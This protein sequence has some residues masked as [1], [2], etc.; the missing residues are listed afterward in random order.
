[1]LWLYH[2]SALLHVPCSMSSAFS[3][4]VKQ[5]ENKVKAPPLHIRFKLME[6]PCLLWLSNASQQTLVYVHHTT[7]L[8]FGGDA[9]RREENPLSVSEEL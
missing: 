7:G 3:T 1:M 9:K 6:S 2:G 4:C 8:F 5:M